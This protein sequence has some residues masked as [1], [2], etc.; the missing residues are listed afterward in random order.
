M[1]VSVLK[2]I[3]MGVSVLKQMMMILLMIRNI[4]VLDYIISLRGEVWSHHFTKRGGLVTSF[5]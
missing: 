4:K 3:L 2:Q 1:G 5:H